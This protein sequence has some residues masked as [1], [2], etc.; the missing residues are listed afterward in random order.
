MIVV[1]WVC[2]PI[3]YVINAGNKH[4]QLVGGEVFVEFS[5]EGILTDVSPVFVQIAIV[6]KDV[7]VIVALLNRFA[8]TM[9]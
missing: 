7:I 2:Q 6:A 3:A 9:S 1:Q 8:G 5:V 4:R